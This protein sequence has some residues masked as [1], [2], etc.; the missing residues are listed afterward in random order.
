[1]CLFHIHSHFTLTSF[2]QR[3]HT[4]NYFRNW[5]FK[6]LSVSKYL[7]MCLYVCFCM[8]VGIHVCTGICMYLCVRG[9]VKIPAV[10]GCW[11]LSIHPHD[12][13]TRVLNHSAISPGPGTAWVFVL[14][15]VD[16]FDYFRLIVMCLNV[17]PAHLYVQAWNP[18][19]Y[20]ETIR[21]PAT[22]VIDDWQPRHGSRELNPGP[23]QELSF[24]SSLRNSVLIDCRH[25]NLGPSPKL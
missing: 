25:V 8:N 19:R 11:D 10:H 13:K 12:F 16:C 21:S 18:S 14:V 24:I 17:L 9:G 22:G 4:P 5:V 2:W 6:D 20:K 7:C 1:M 3:T 23:L 15:V